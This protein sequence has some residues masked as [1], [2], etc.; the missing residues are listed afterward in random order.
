VK[1]SCGSVSEIKVLLA[2]PEP[3][4]RNEVE[5]LVKKQ[6]RLAADCFV[7]PE[8]VRFGFRREGGGRK[9]GAMDPLQILKATFEKTYQTDMPNGWL[10]CFR[11]RAG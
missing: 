4:F 11:R 1:R 9:T 3:M 5:E 10:N 6:E 8:R 2:E 7:L